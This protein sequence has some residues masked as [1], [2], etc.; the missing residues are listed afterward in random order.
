[1]EPE[2]VAM[3]APASPDRPLA[4]E[5][6]LLRPLARQFPT[7]ELALAEIA[8]LEGELTLPRAA[9]HVVSDVH[10]E[11]KKLRHILNNGSGTLRPVVEGLFAGRLDDGEI[12]E[13]LTLLFYPR[14]TLE[15]LAPELDSTEELRRFCR[16]TARRL[17]EVIRALGRGRT[18]ERLHRDDPAAFRTLFAELLSEPS[19]AREAYVDAMIDS[20]VAHGYGTEVVRR[21]ARVARNLAVDELIVAGD[22]Y[23]RGPRADRVVE[24]VRRH[25][26]VA[27]VWGNHDAAW[28]GA[29]LGQPALIGHVL[30]VS[31]RYR[32]LSQLEEGYGITLQPLE[33]LVREVYADDPAER[34]RPR[35]EGL[36]EVETL[37]RMQKAAAILQFKLEGQ[38]IARNPEMELE[39]RRLLHRIDRDGGTIEIDGRRHPLADRSFPTIDPADPYALSPEEQACLDRIRASFLASPV[40]WEHMTFL[41]ERGSMWLRRD[42]HLIFHG[43]VPVDDAGSFLSF[44]VDGVERRGRALFEAFDEVIARALSERRE[45][46]LDLLWYLWCGPRSPLFGKDRITT[47]ERDLVADA[48][49]HVETKNP[50]FKQIH[51]ADFCGRVLA[52]FGVSADGMIV[53]GHVPVKIEKGESPLKRSGHAITIDGAFSEAYGDHGYTLLIEP[54]RTALAMHHHF[55]SVEAAVRD[56]VDII[57]TVTTVREYDRPRRVATGERG[58]EIRAEIALLE[59]LVDS[60]RRGVLR[61]RPE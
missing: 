5:L 24:A 12:R 61:P 57:P 40:L 16:R 7:V 38:T 10:G 44:P 31:I 3:T 20:F 2:G 51:E 22:C 34:F 59:R 47:L 28:L 23:D 33:H 27:F 30:R 13:L 53:N 45:K 56:G 55:E 18:R 58:E 50:Y 4:S 21:A 6:A 29:C 46:D 26:N 32:R 15:R 1:M 14:E 37:S 60:Y 42:D 39:H 25:P 19:P 11:F 41:G 36:R 35:G 9:I 17:G 52:E 8:R 48:G 43:C 49:T 54:D